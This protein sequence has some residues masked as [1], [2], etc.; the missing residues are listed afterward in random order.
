MSW[1]SDEDREMRA[2]LTS[3]EAALNANTAEYRAL[4]IALHRLA[5]EFR[6]FADA[7]HETPDED[8]P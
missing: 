8:R 2:R 7:L 5:S 3:M 6:R 4:R 1:Q